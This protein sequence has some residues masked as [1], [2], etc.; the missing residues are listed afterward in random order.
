M[1]VFLCLLLLAI[2]HLFV[3]SNFLFCVPRKSADLA[4]RQAV[5]LYRYLPS[6]GETQSRWTRGE[7][8]EEFPGN[9]DGRDGLALRGGGGIS[10]VPCMNTTN[11]HE[12]D[13]RCADGERKELAQRS[14]G[15]AGSSTSPS[16]A[17]GRSLQRRVR[18]R[19]GC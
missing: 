9:N 18:G 11:G 17:R 1:R 8:G 19:R 3:F 13:G 16:V 5:G 12:R 10:R 15:R 14:P 7:G 4:D 2:T 6:S